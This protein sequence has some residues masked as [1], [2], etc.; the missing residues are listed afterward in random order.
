MY[1][2]SPSVDCEYIFLLVVIIKLSLPK[3]RQEQRVESRDGSQ[4]QRNT[5]CACS[6]HQ[7]SSLLHMGW[8]PGEEDELAPPVLLCTQLLKTDQGT[9]PSPCSCTRGP[10]S[11]WATRGPPALPVQQS[12]PLL[13]VGDQ[14]TPPSLCSSQSSPP[15]AAFQVVWHSCHGCA[16]MVVFCVVNFRQKQLPSSWRKSEWLV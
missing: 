1:A 5:S 10:F 4:P 13:C 8:W 14:G 12:G 7:S 3:A 6:E 16:N 9:P 11:V 15:Q 2:R